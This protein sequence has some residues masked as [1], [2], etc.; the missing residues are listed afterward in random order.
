M[1]TTSVAFSLLTIPTE[2]PP[3]SKKCRLSRVEVI[4]WSAQRISPVVNISFLDRNLYFYFQYLRPHL[5]SRGWVDPV[6]KPPHPRKYMQSFYHKNTETRGAPS[7]R[8]QQQTNTTEAC[9]DK[10]LKL[11]M[12]E[13]VWEENGGGRG[14]ELKWWS[15][16]GWR[17]EKLTLHLV[18]QRGRKLYAW[19]NNSN[20]GKILI[21]CMYC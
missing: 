2:R 20:W 18:T 4:V 3:L 6:T 10:Q 9:S 19:R 17:L 21:V 7:M 12:D 8:P 5:S 11:W 13:E 1:Q 15:A 14:V 16:T